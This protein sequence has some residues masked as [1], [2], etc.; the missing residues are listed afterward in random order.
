MMKGCASFQH[1]VFC[2]AI[3]YAKCRIW[4]QSFIIAGFLEIRSVQVST[5]SL[6]DENIHARLM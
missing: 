5:T 1:S 4:K 3:G 2:L 6:S